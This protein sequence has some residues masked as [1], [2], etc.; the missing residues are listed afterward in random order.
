MATPSKRVTVPKPAKKASRQPAAKPDK[1]SAHKA[2]R[3]AATSRHRSPPG[4]VRLSMMTGD[5]EIVRAL[6]DGTVKPKGIELVIGG[7]PGTSDIHSRVAEGKG[8][9]IN[10]Y[11]GGHYVV[12]RAHGRDDFTAIPVFLHRRFRHGFIYI[13]QSKGIREPK[14][15]IGKR[16]GSYSIGP[17]ANYWMRGYLE[18]AGVPHKSATWVVE[19]ADEASEQAPGDLKV[20]VL[21]R[22]RKV[23]DML[24]NGEIDAMISPSVTKMIDMKDP[25]VGRLWPNYREVEADYY[26]RTGF[27][28][29]MHVTTVPSEIV[30]RYPWVV[31][32]LTYAFE[33]AKQ[34]A[35]QRLINPR[36]VPLAWYRSCWEEERQLLGPDPWEYGMSEINRRNYDTLVGYVH[37]QVLTGRRP[38]LEELFP[39]EA[40]ELQLPLPKMHDTVYG[41]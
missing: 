23:E 40:F 34:L 2:R 24:L 7:Y 22:G 20:E 15:L 25:R 10:E 18:D 39:K 1:T 28:P 26:R 13:N 16:I 27:F 38:R 32:S 21:E 35:Y 37:H 4:K 5:Y 30:A 11:N 3:P 6:K 9:D 31:E 17:A 14:D 8:C 12:Q 19:H 41:F 36:I 29:I 33:E